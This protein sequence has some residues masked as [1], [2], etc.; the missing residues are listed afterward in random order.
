M[1]TPASDAAATPRPG[2]PRRLWVVL[3]LALLQGLVLGAAGAGVIAAREQPELADALGEVSNAATA[4]LVTGVV[5][6]LLG[7]LRIGLALLLL[8]GSEVARSW[9]GAAAMLQTAIGVY[10]VV[11]LQDLGEA[12]VVPVALSVTELWLLYGS[13]DVHRFFVT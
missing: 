4:L 10:V 7:V 11:G 12:G 6:V 2:R 1:S 3:A 13:D 5:L 8:R 9:F